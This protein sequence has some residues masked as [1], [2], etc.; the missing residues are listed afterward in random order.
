MGAVEKVSETSSMERER[1]KAAAG[2]RVSLV[3]VA[4]GWEGARRREEKMGGALGRRVRGKRNAGMGRR[5]R[6]QRRRARLRVEQWERE[7]VGREV[8]QRLD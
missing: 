3:G 5:K 8:Q 6:R 7:Q 1:L 2:S 4:V